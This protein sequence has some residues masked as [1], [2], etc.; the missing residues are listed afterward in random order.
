MD[1]VVGVGAFIGA[2]LGLIEALWLAGG[3][4]GWSGLG[5]ALLTVVLLYAIFG[6]ALAPLF[7]LLWR[8]LPFHTL[9]GLRFEAAAYGILFGSA[10][11]LIDINRLMPAG[12]LE[13]KSLILDTLVLACEVV[14][15]AVIVLAFRARA[16]GQITYRSS[17][18]VTLGYGICT[19]LVL[20]AT[21]VNAWIDSEKGSPLAHAAILEAPGKWEVPPAGAQ[22]PSNSFQ[23]G[24]GPV[25]H[26]GHPKLVVIGL[27]GATWS[28]MQPLIERGRLPN[29]AAL[30][31]T[32]IGG[33]L[34]STQ[35][36][37]SPIVW[38]T[39]FTGK[40]PA[41]HGIDAIQRARSVNRNVHAL[42]NILSDHDE[43]LLAG[44]VPGTY[45]A[46]PIRGAMFSGFP[47]ENET[48]NNLG[49][50]FSTRSRSQW[51]R[52]SGVTVGR[53]DSSTHQL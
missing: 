37:F 25:A 9:H 7:S 15:L 47:N 21:G 4:A 19:A 34:R 5:W 39:L 32:G 29:I 20:A 28:L 17:A 43:T 41:K 23:A 44:N 38:T 46:E 14:I 53:L 50:V 33:A 42:W 1:F 51:D 45:P 6:A 30:L 3:P 49:Y 36:S 35:D 8:R 16:S 31:S 24:A 10:L 22:N 13:M 52:L 2:L 48:G 26:P 40:V 12:A 18:R 11:L 27:D